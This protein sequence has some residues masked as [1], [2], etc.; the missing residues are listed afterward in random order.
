MIYFIFEHKKSLLNYFIATVN[1]TAE[2][3]NTMVS[4]NLNHGV[5]INNF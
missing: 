1:L 2:Y 4:L 3:K 5:L